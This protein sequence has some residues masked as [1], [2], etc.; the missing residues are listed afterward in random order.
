MT[1]SQNQMPAPDPEAVCGPRVPGT[2][3]PA[4]MS[5]LAQLNPCPLKA[6]CNVWGQCGINSDFCIPSPADSGAPGAVT[7]GSN[8]CIANC[9]MD[10]V[11]N[12]NPAP[13]FKRIGYWEAW[14]DRRPCLH[15]PAR[16]ID[17][18]KYT[19]VVRYPPS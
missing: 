17:T 10:I 14:N 3:Q 8:G 2:P 11:N 16:F 15:M 12:A 6:C 7:P 4:N 5:T 1:D 18:T 19:H 13:S 9:G